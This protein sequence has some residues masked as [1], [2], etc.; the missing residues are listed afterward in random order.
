[1]KISGSEQDGVNLFLPYLP[2]STLKNA[3]WTTTGRL[4]KVARR[5]QIGLGTWYLNVVVNEFAF[6]LPYT[7]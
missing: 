4:W 2:L 3:R 7:S 1:M 6:C 5:R